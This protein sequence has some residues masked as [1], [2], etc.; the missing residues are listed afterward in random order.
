[1]QASNLKVN[2]RSVPHRKLHAPS[3]LV[4]AGS[5]ATKTVN[6]LACTLSLKFQNHECLETISEVTLLYDSSYA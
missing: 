2:A 3:A 5:C 4:N 1:M 6:Y